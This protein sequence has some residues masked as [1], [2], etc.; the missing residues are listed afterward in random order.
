MGSDLLSRTAGDSSVSSFSGKG[1]LGLF[2]SGL[3]PGSV[4]TGLGNKDHFAQQQCVS[5]HFPLSHFQS[6]SLSFQVL[7]HFCSLPM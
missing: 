4:L 5:R 7:E 1:H 6:A 2:C 3:V